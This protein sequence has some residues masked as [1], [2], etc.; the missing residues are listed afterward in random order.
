MTLVAI[1]VP[2]VHTAS[3]CTSFG[4]ECRFS[5]DPAYARRWR[6]VALSTPSTAPQRDRL[7]WPA[8]PDNQFEN[9]S[10]G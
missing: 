9:V 6:R 2:G 5:S 7:A 1:H 3:L 8:T 10:A 4:D